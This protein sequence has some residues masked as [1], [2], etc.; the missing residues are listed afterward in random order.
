[1]EQQLAHLLAETQSSQETP[2][3][4]AE[5]QLRQLYHDPNFPIGLVTL[6]SHNDVPLNIRQSALLVCKK[7]VEAGWSSNLDEFAGQVLINDTNKAT[8]RQVIMGIALSETDERRVKSAAS[9]V[10]SKI[11]TADFPED[12]PN[13]L[14]DLLALIP[15]ASDARLHGAL[16]LLQDLI[17]D[18]LNEEQFFKSAHDL[19]RTIYEVAANESRKTTLRAL[20]IASFRASFDLLEMVLEDHKSAVKGFAEQTLTGWMPFFIST[21]GAPL[22]P[23]PPEDD[24]GQKDEAVGEHYRGMVALKLQVVKVLMRVRAIFPSVLAPHSPALFSAVWDQLSHL[25]TQYS[26]FYIEGDRQGRLE[27]A[28]GLPYTLDFLVLE[29]LD[30]MQACLRAPPVKKELQRQLQSPET[31]GWLIEFV[32]L[33]I[34]YAHITTEEEGLWDFDVNLFL[35]EESSLTANYT[36]RT[37]CGDLVTK[38]VDW[39]QEPTLEALNAQIKSTFESNS[40]WKA[41]EAALFVL[42]SLL[43]ELQEMDRSIGTEIAHNLVPFLEQTMQQ[44][45]DLLRAR[46]HLVAGALL[47]TAGG[48]LS[49]V[50]SAFMQ[51]C[52]NAMVSDDS[53]VVK[54]SCVRALQQYLS[55]VSK[56][57]TRPLQPHMIDGLANFMSQQD[58]DSLADLEDT[59]INLMETLRAVLCLDPI[60]CIDGNGLTLFFS[61]AKVNASSFQVAMLATETLEEIATAASDAGPEVFARLCSKTVPFLNEAFNGDGSDEED[62]L[63]NMAA[64]LLTV[65]TENSPSP[66]PNGFVSSMM[67]TLQRALLGST[68][69]ALIRSAT[70]SLKFMLEHDADAIFAWQD[71]EG[72][73]GLEVLLIIV[74]RL[75]GPSIDDNAAGEVGGLAAAL[76]EKAESRL[77]PYLTQL[78]QAVAMRLATAEKA[79]IIQS[80]ILVFARLTNISAAEVVNFLAGI[81]IGNGTGLQ[82][83]MS[84]WLENSVHFAG[85]DEIRQKSA[86]LPTLTPSLLSSSFPPRSRK[87]RITDPRSIAA[88]TK[89]YDLNSPLLSDITV[90]GDLI[91][92]QNQSSRIITRSRARLMP[93]QYTSVDANLKIMKLLIE[94]LQVEKAQL[95]PASAAAAAGATAAL[96]DEDDLDDGEDDGEWE[97]D[98]RD[99]LDL[100]SGMTKADLMALGTR[101]DDE[102]DAMR[103]YGGRL[104]GNDDDAT[105]EVLTGWFRQTVAQPGFEGVFEKLREG[106]KDKLRRVLG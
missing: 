80:L 43:I 25:Q 38:L 28:D 52:M 88:L 6:A 91:V 76:V 100:G 56:E 55:A 45:H 75:L 95:D 79:Q 21:I 34:A 106:E 39:I 2:R 51:R 11:A 60:A 31:S 74:D 47:K 35:S 93:T 1:M 65:L 69:D 46:T 101:D 29:E 59:M 63:A 12:W 14:S 105:Q 78:L 104:T 16:K 26:A 15:Q 27:D 57:I 10:I 18:C 33:A 94:E 58:M 71:A 36:P 24:E 5:L 87:Y 30:F 20:A 97:D 41:R 70:T 37:A 8:V 3:K 7:F 73:S 96:G 68:D 81:H 84:K 85:Y 53:D 48:N 98:P 89:L 77:G 13:L 49:N 82:I 42:N 102:D 72:K 9:L 99:F 92:P 50:H 103:R 23:A 90:Q 22:P 17:E 32:K 83:V 54:V 64:E 40:G 61:I 19:V 4:Q 86:S 44:E 66:L 62:V 67:P